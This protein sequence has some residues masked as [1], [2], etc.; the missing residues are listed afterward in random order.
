MKT[1][2]GGVKP[3]EL[4]DEDLRNELSSLYRTREDTFLNGSE[5]S[6]EEHTKRMFD[7]EREF[8]KR[9]PKETRPAARRTREG[10]RGDKAPGTKSKPQP[11]TT[12]PRR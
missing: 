10:A 9:F 1:A 5:Q 3:S 11:S 8:L 2:T 6:L 12:R 4:D 7:L